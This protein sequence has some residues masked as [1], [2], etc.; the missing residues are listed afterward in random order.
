MIYVN[1][2]YLS[3]VPINI[4]F[5]S[6]RTLHFSKFLLTLKPFLAKERLFCPHSTFK[7]QNSF[8][9]E[10]ITCTPKI[11]LSIYLFKQ[12][13]I[14]DPFTNVF[15]NSSEIKSNT[16]HTTIQYVSRSLN[17]IANTICILKQ[18]NLCLKLAY[19]PWLDQRLTKF[20]YMMKLLS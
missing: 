4:Y 13:V 8:L 18:T 12:L 15:F 6:K 11:Y 20:K 16:C 17:H 7:Y 1:C 9:I 14:A 3:F 5:M 2:I 19:R 10:T